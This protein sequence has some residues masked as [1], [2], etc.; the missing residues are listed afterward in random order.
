M[1]VAHLQREAGRD[2]VSVI[3]EAHLTG[4]YLRLGK[5]GNGHTW[6]RDQF[7]AASVDR[8]K[9][10]QQ[11]VVGIILIRCGQHGTAENNALSLCQRQ[12]VAQHSGCVVNGG[13]YRGLRAGQGLAGI[14]VIDITD[15]NAHPA[16]DVDVV[17][18]I[19]DAGGAADH[20]AIAQP[21][22]IEGAKSVGV[23]NSRG[24]DVQ[25]DML[26]RSAADCR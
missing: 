1:A 18:R 20:S 24:I 11:A 10:E 8:G 23:A 12:L 26:S 5:A 7:K 6:I 14:I 15:F 9:G 25:R 4:V 17:Q 16:A 2:V 22:I 21:L 13:Y 19:A 3:H